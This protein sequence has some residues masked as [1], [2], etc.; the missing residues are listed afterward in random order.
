MKNRFDE[1]VDILNA[2]MI[3]M[4]AMIE[5]TIENAC[6]ALQTANLPK[7]REIMEADSIVDRKEREIESLCLRMLL[8]RQPVAHD[9]RV[10]SSALKMITDMERIGDH[11]ADISEIVTFMDYSAA[12]QP[13]HFGAMSR[14]AIEMVHRAI[15]AYV[16]QDVQLA[17]AV[18]ASDDTVD[19]L[20][21]DV[22]RELIELLKAD[23]SRGS[24]ALDLLMIAKYFERIGDHATNI[25]EWVE[26]SVTGIYKG[27]VLQ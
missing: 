1:Q 6:D 9:L 26:Y 17:R 22:K 2:Q 4:G 27:E 5:T 20:F 7:A 15:D 10:V 19:E 12:M 8:T 25:A 24:E 23:S 21:V 16:R 18:I 13:E 11:A 3:E 14:A